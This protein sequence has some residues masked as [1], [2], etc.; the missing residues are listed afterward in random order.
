[1][2]TRL[3]A[4]ALLASAALLSTSAFSDDHGDRGDRHDRDD[5]GIFSFA[6]FGDW[7][8]SQFL[9]DNSHLLINSVNH[10]RRVDLVIHVGDI[11]SGSM[12]CTSAYTLPPLASSNPG[13]NQ[14]VFAAFQ[15][16]DAPLIYTPG[17]NEWSDCHK[18]KEKSAGHPL[19]ELASVRELFFSRPGLSLG[20]NPMQVWTQAEHYDPSYPADAQFVENV[21]WLQHDLLF[22]TLNVPGGSNDDTTA[23]TGDFANPAAQAQ[24]VQERQAANLRWLAKAFQIA[25][26]EHARAVV[27]AIQADLWDPEALPSVGGKGLDQ[28]T[29]LV[30]SIATQ[31]IKFRR[32]VLLLNGDTHK[33]GSDRPL[34]DPAS[35]TGIIYNTPAVPNLLR[36]VVQGSAEFSPGEWLKVTVDPRDPALFSWS[37]V[38][39][40]SDPV[41][42]TCN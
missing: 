37:N 36:I 2:S 40:C 31:S 33:Y 25:Q 17:D 15:K 26:R 22:V 42:S 1:M 32:P 28:Y 23:W 18:S 27:L 10:D 9:L 16:F 30:K 5:N 13:W 4:C 7:P 39:Y 41:N 11:H 38:V 3:A 20:R 6:V 29:D 35:T 21:L 8:Y 14:S 34:A 12:P 19:R 24:E